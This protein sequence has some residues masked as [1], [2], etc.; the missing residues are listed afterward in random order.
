MPSPARGY[1]LEGRRLP[2]VT[3]ILG[4]FKKSDQLLRWA[5]RMG[6]EGKSMDDARD[7]AASVGTHCHAML[8]AYL[9]KRPA[10]RFPA[11]FTDEQRDAAENGFGM[12][13]DWA[14]K[15]KLEIVSLETPMVSRHQRVGGTPDMVARIN[16]RLAMGDWKF[17]NGVYVEHLVQ[18][19]EYKVIWEENHPDEPINGGFH[20]LRFSREHGDWAHRYFDDLSDAEE[21]FRLYRQAYDLDQRLAKRVG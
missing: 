21:L 4:R 18:I 13:L 20:L 5:N 17:S 8:E 19:A 16:S 7:S 1:Y 6:L 15:S 9:K 12:F 2:S 3:T 14:D 11:E 10:P